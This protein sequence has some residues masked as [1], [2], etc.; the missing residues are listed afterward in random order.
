MVSKESTDHVAWINLPQYRPRATIKLNRHATLHNLRPTRPSY[1]QIPRERPKPINRHSDQ[2]IRYTR[3]HSTVILRAC[4][5]CPEGET[6]PAFVD[7]A[8]GIETAEP[9]LNSA[10]QRAAI[11]ETN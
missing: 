11:A 7:F 9:S 10:A 6:K 2:I 3:F 5:I 8:R 4:P 1:H